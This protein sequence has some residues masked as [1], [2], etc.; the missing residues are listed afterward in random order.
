MTGE[1]QN[2]TSI[3]GHGQS[4]TRRIERSSRRLTRSTRFISSEI[5]HGGE[6][7]EL[8]RWVKCN[9]PIVIL[10]ADLSASS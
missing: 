9:Q 3:R 6:D 5:G 2:T 1:S 10:F 7:K 8:Q 4:G